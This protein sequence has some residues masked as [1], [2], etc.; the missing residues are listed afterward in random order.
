MVIDFQ[1]WFTIKILKF[2]YSNSI[3][4]YTT[5]H[6]ENIFQYIELK[7]ECWDCWV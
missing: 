6:D 4:L 5:T 7:L 2:K 1:I 3:D